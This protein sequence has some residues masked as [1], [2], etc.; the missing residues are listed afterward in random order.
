MADTL[1]SLG[2]FSE[3]EAS[4]LLALFASE[5]RPLTL[6]DFEC[7]EKA[8]TDLYKAA[9]EDT[10]NARSVLLVYQMLRESHSNTNYFCGWRGSDGKQCG[11]RMDILVTAAGAY[12]ECRKDRSHKTP[13]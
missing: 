7:V 1:Y 9:S 6:P 12:Y 8:V 4:D 5:Q 11:S 10:L 13:K 2:Y 3:S